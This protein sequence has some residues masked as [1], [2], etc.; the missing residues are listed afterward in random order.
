M[1][2]QH[3]RISQASRQ[4]P[5]F[6]V[7]DVLEKAMEMAENGEDI[8][9]LE[10]GEPDF[11]TPDNIVQAGIEAMRAGKTHYTPSIGIPELRRA[12]AAH[13]RERYGAD[14]DPQDVV[15]TSGS[16]PAILLILSALLDPGSEIIL[17]NPHYACYPNF[18]RFLGGEPVFVSVSP[19]DGFQLNPD[20]VEAAITD[21]TRAI[22]INSPSNPTGIVMEPYRMKRLAQLHVPIISDEIYHGLTYEGTEHS[23]L[24]FTRNAFAVNGFSKLYAMT[25]WRL[26]YLIL[27][28]E[29]LRPIQKMIQNFFI[30]PAD[31]VQ[32]AGVEALTNSS[33]QTRAMKETF[34][35]RRLAM[36]SRLKHMGFGIKVDPTAAFYVLADA[37]KFSGDSYTF[38]FE[39]LED[40]GVGVAPGIDFGENAEGFL[41]FSYTNSI[42]NIH[43]GL[44]RIELYL[45]K[46]FGHSHTTGR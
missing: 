39:I 36:I 6:L 4:I 15:I 12:V 46:R 13:Y 44:D 20:E 17:A 43:I 18:I 41:R 27:I 32:W 28:Q 33:D 23:I 14:V 22:L 2:H 31:F 40:A 7:M 37:R 16:S 24:E 29:Y 19:D 8:I 26:G 45:K 10:V 3:I 42:E 25:G 35:Q 30:S 11:D 5:P 9:H 1:D 38:A 34:N 21:R